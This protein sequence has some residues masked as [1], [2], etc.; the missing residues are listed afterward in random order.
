[1]NSF[2]IVRTAARIFLLIFSAVQ[3]L[4]SLGEAG[5]Q[6]A[7]LWSITLAL[8]LGSFFDESR[9]QSYRSLERKIDGVYVKETSNHD[10]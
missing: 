5:Y 3:M 7:A 10:C 1:M 4:L 8:V 9:R 6:T 2:A